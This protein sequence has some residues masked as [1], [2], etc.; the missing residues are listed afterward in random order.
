MQTPIRSGKSATE[1]YWLPGIVAAFYAIIC[2]QAAVGQNV[3]DKSYSAQIRANTTEPY[4]STGLVNHLPKSSTVPTPQQ[5]LGY[6]IGAPG[7]LTYSKDIYAYYRALAK[8]SP[9]VKVFSAGKTEEGR[10]F[11]MVVV[12]SQSNIVSWIA[13]K[14]SLQSWLTRAPFPTIWPMRLN[15]KASRFTGRQHPFIRLRQA[16]QKC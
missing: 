1:R 14:R 13:I 16:L 3:D 2:L 5:F 6:I 7:H 12:S 8:A 10:E 15:R 9:R 4:L 11:L